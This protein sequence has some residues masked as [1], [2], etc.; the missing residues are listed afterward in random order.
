METQPLVREF[1][2]NGVNL[3]DPN[4]EANVEACRD[5]FAQTHPDIATAAVDGPELIGNKQVF[6]FIKSV[7]TK[8]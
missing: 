7:G 3:P 8:G 5:L 4:P 2:Y 1:R 6:T